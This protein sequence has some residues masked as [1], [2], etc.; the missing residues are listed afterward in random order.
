[1]LIMGISKSNSSSSINTYPETIKPAYST[2][3]EIIPAKAMAELEIIK[4]E[5]DKS[6]SE[7]NPGL[8]EI[9]LLMLIVVA[10]T[11]IMRFMSVIVFNA[12]QESIL[13]IFMQS[14]GILGII[15][16]LIQFGAIAILLSTRDVMIAKIIILIVG[17][18][19]AINIVQRLSYFQISA[20]MLFDIAS[21]VVNVYIFR[22][23]FYVWQNL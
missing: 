7:R 19:F 11:I 6:I 4:I 16:I 10:T 13:K 5:N 23:V 2:G 22:K 8:R 20:S 21:L 12:S 18:G 9:A 1:M 15:T 17:I 3:Q 14:I